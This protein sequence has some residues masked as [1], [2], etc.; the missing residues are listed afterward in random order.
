VDGAAGD[1]GRDAAGGRRGPPPRSPRACSRI[2][3]SRTPGC[4]CSRSTITIRGAA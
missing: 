3:A 1:P 4:W 2:S